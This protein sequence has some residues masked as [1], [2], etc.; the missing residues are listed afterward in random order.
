LCFP[1]DRARKRRGIKEDNVSRFRWF[2]LAF[3]IPALFTL[4]ACGDDDDDEGD[5]DGGSSGPAIKLGF[6]AWPGWFPWQVAEEAGIFE[7]AGVEV[8]LVWF[9]GYL[10]SINALAARQLDAN[11]QTLNDT[12]G[13][14]A[15]GSDQV[16]VLVNDNSTGNDQIIASKEITSIKDLKGKR[17]GLE[18]GVVD[19][20]L[21]SWAWRRK[22]CLMTSR[23]STRD[24]RRRCV[25]CF[26]PLDAVA[27]FAPFTTQALEREGFTR[28]S[29]R[30]T[31]WR[32]PRPSDRFEEAHRRAA[33]R[34]PEVDRRLVLTFSTST[35]TREAAEIMAERAGVSEEE[36]ASYDGH[37][38]FSAEDNVEGIRAGEHAREPVRGRG[39]LCVHAG[40]RADREGGRSRPFD[41]SFVKPTPRS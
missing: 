14:V 33:G 25:I 37:H 38:L 36:Y 3:L 39:H 28:S 18:E 5:D 20:Y 34:R 1:G 32:H 19:H 41:A 9:E 6:S 13:S 2:V 17:I 12:I 30:R 10:D 27:V 7:K 8:E 26:R 4:A 16:I 31:S 40:G 21:R 11:S 22:A 29:A 35:T 23:S 24:W 15:A